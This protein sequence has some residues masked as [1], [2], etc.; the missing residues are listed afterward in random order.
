[1]HFIWDLAK[2]YPFPPKRLAL[3][4]MTFLIFLFCAFPSCV[5]TSPFLSVRVSCP[6][7]HYPNT[8]GLP[9]GFLIPLGALGQDLCSNSLPW[10]R[11]PRCLSPERLSGDHAPSDTRRES[12]CDG[13]WQAGDGVWEAATWAVPPQAQGSRKGPAALSP[14]QLGPS[15]S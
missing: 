4:L 2:V 5:P 15:P 11:P 8:A 14:G 6:L 13:F 12:C 7:C 9:F 10:S 3:L 1:M